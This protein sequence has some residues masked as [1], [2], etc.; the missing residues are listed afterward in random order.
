MNRKNHHTYEISFSFFR[1]EIEKSEFLRNV[2]DWFEIF[3][4]SPN[5][6]GELKSQN[7]YLDIRDINE[8]K[9]KD[10]LEIVVEVKEELKDLL[11]NAAL[12]NKN[13]CYGCKPLS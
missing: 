9:A 10:S 11:L 7:P 1:G 3:N 2:Y 4:V 12:K 8:N 6:R 13:I 5:E